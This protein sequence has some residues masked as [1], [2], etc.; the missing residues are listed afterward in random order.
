M[1]SLFVPLH[2]EQPLTWNLVACQTQRRSR[3]LCPPRPHLTHLAHLAPA[4]VPPREPLLRDVPLRWP[5]QPSR[6]DALLAHSLPQQG[7]SAFANPAPSP[8]STP[9][10]PC[11]AQ[12]FSRARACGE[13]ADGAAK[14]GRQAA[15]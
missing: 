5:R 6:D 1:A 4:T 14:W 3:L 10:L 15:E 7:C 8:R 12:H 13:G 2:R 11:Q 9:R